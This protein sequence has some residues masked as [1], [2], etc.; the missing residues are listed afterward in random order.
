[1]FSQRD[2]ADFLPS[3]GLSPSK[4]KHLP[5]LLCIPHYC[6]ALI[7]TN[8]IFPNYNYFFQRLLG[9]SCNSGKLTISQILSRS[10]VLEKGK[11]RAGDTAVCRWPAYGINW[12]R[13]FP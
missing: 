3:H 12:G 6:K 5:I 11:I 7:Q 10:S 4:K 1:M 9:I 13:G 8:P 2:E